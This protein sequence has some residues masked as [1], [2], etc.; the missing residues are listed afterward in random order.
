MIFRTRTVLS[1][2][3]NRLMVDVLS[4]PRDP[5]VDARARVLRH[6]ERMTS[7]PVPITPEYAA[8]VLAEWDDA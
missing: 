4:R 8:Q 6:F 2:A 7:N 3:C 1:R 5:V